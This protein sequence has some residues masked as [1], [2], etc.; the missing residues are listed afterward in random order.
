MTHRILRP[1]PAAILA[2]CLL[3][4]VLSPGAASAQT[5]FA[6]T[7]EAYIIQEEL[8]EL[9]TVVAG[10]MGFLFSAPL[11]TATHEIN[12]LGFNSVDGLLYGWHRTSP[13]NASAAEQNPANQEVV[14]IDAAGTITALGVPTGGG[15][16]A[17]P[18]ASERFTSGDVSDDGTTLYLNNNGTGTLWIVPVPA[19]TG[20]TS[21]TITGGTGRVSDWAYNRDDGN[22]YGGDDTDGQLAVLTT[23]GTRTDGSVGGGGLPTGQGFGAAW[24]DATG[25]LFLYRND[26]T[27]YEIADPTGTPTVV[28]TQTG[29]SSTKNDGAACVQDVLGAAKSMTSSAGSGLPSTITIT[30]VFENFDTVTALTSMSAIDDLTAVFGTHGVDW[31]FVSISSSTGTFHNGSFDGHTSA[32]T[33]QLINQAPT[34][35]L[36]ASPGPGNTATITVTLTLLTHAGDTDMDD[37]FCNQIVATGDLGGVTFGDVSTDGS[38]PDPGGDD[39]PEEDDPSCFTVPVELKEFSLR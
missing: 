13:S 8:A 24:F 27:I 10:P 31:T 38:D 17:T 30:Y 7:G 28:S 23:A 32:A 15:F 12:N 29:P 36:S 39:I 37:I 33:M 1:A 4:L 18:T 2:C 22:L 5:P 9:R 21:A 3:G 6:C 26:G 19:L 34:Q 16:P 35:G 11:V 20:T 14:T 25:T